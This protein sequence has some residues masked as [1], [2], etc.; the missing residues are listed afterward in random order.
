[1]KRQLMKKETMTQRTRREIWDGL[2]GKKEQN[3]YNCT[4]ISKIIKVQKFERKIFC[5]LAGWI[6]IFRGMLTHD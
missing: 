2:K 6:F 4:I 3:K 5:H 1:M